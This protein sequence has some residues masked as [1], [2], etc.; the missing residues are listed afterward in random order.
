MEWSSHKKVLKA[1]ELYR[2][3]SA[4][5]ESILSLCIYSQFR[6]ASHCVTNGSCSLPLKHTHSL[7][8]RETQKERDHV[9]HEQLLV[10][11]L[12][13]NKVHCVYACMHMSH[14]SGSCDKS[15][16]SSGCH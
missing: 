11:L 1:K 7:S 8:E 10:F 5:Q 15:H 9:S 2:A 16:Y 4:P 14:T 12:F 6:G 3:I 13:I